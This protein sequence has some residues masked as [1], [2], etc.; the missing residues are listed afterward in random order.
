MAEAFAGPAIPDDFYCPITYQVMDEPVIHNCGRTFNKKS[1]EK[2]FSQKNIQST[3]QFYIM[4]FFYLLSLFSASFA[5]FASCS[6][7]T[8]NSCSA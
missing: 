7:A 2:Y 1:I 6:A 4:S 3:D 8:A 5:S